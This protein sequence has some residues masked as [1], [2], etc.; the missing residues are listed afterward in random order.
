[1]AIAGAWRAK[2]D[3]PIPNV[4]YLTE[5]TGINPIH[6]VHSSSRGRD[7][8]PGGVVGQIDDGLTDQFAPE[9]LGYCDEDT[10]SVLWGYGVETGTADRPSLD[11]SDSGFRRATTEHYPQYGQYMAGVPGGTTIRAMEHGALANSTP[12]VMPDEDAAQGWMNKVRSFLLDSVDSAPAQL[13]VQTSEVQ[14]D[15]VRR[16]SQTPAGR[17]NEYDAPITQAIP[18]MRLKI[19]SGQERHSEMMPKSQDQ[20]IRPFWLRTAGTG[21]P[22]NMEPNAMVTNSPV[23]RVPP[24]DPY[25]GRETSSVAGYTDEDMVY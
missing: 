2:Q 11:V 16:G 20:I 13:L 17:E 12:K 19:Y 24:A 7:I 3:S 4:G 9:N 10:S 1:M 21:D 22:A 25:T 15:T 23:M 18:G 14:R 8:A 6:S 5:G